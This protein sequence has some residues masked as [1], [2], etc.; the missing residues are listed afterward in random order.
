MLV[1]DYV[2]QFVVSK[3]VFNL[4]FIF[5]RELDIVVLDSYQFDFDFEC[6]IRK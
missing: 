3:D 4:Q 6:V 1:F 5:D 2:V